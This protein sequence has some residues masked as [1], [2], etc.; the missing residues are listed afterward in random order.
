MKKI[1]LT[2]MVVSWSCYYVFS[3]LLIKNIESPYIEGLG[4]R[5]ITFILMSLVFLI[6]K[7][8]IHHFKNIKEFIQVIS[9]ACAVFLFDC[10]I[11]I[12]LMFSSAS[13]G[14]ALLKT[15]ILFVFLINAIIYKK[16][17]SAFDSLVSI[18]M[19]LGTL[20]IVIKDI[21]DIT[22]DKWSL[23]FVAS[24]VINSVCAFRIKAL[25]NKYNIES[26]QMAY[27]NNAVSL[28]LYFI[29]SFVTAYPSRI[30]SC[31][32]SN[33]R[34]LG[35]CSVCQVTLMLSY[36]YSLKNMSVRLTK[37]ILLFVPILTLM[38]QLLLSYVTIS[39]TQLIGILITLVSSFLFIFIENKKMREDI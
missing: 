9:V 34:Q 1:I 24:A 6:K 22:F 7:E 28:L 18:I 15:E 21:K 12:G 17:I 23:I 27:I 10:L 32:S 19:F 29:T 16:R 35:L 20:L 31:I 38:I 30:I 4:I 3:N 37:V 25:Q 11:N 33:I 8:K 5:I 13:I 26:N 2:V 36:Y 14:T 39:T